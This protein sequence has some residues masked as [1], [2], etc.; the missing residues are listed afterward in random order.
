VPEE[1]NG[2]VLRFQVSQNTRRLDRLESWQSKVDEDRTT[3][4]ETLRTVHRDMEVLTAEVRRTREQSAMEYATTRRLLVGL[5]A[6]LATTG[7]G[8]ALT[9]LLATGRL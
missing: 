9:V 3:V 4:R 2:G 5:L 8:F 7:I 1:G 6:T